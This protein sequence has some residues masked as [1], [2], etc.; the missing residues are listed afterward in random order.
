MLRGA[1]RSIPHR[2]VIRREPPTGFEPVTCSLRVSCSG[3]LSYRG[4]ARPASAGVESLTG[5]EPVWAALQAAALPLGHRD[6]PE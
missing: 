5:F 6:T 4:N 2:C 3:Q 1:G